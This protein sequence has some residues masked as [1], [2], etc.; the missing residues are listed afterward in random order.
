MLSPKSTKLTLFTALA[1]SAEIVRADETALDR[2]VKAPDA[3]FTWKVKEER[4][5]GQFTVTRLEMQSQQWRGT[6]WVHDVLIVRP[7]KIRNPDIAFLFVGGSGDGS[8]Q[9][10]LLK[11]VAD[12][13]GAL[14][15]VVADVPNQPL[16]GGRVE[17][18]LIA[19]TF[20]QFA[21]TGDE[22]WPLLLPM[23][24]S[25]VRG[26]DAIEQ[27]TS[28]TSM[29]RVERFVL[30][31]ASKRGWTTWLAAAVDRRVVG[32]APMVFDMLNM[33]AQTAWAQKVYGRQSERIHD[34]S[35]ADLISRIDD[36]QIARLREWVDPYAYR[37]RYTIPKLVLLGT[38]DPYWTVDS[39]RHYWPGI[40][41]PK[42]IHQT[43]NAGH[44][45]GGG[46]DAINSLATFF[47]AVAERK[48]L[49]KLEWSV[50]R[51]NVESVLQ[52][53]ADQPMKTARLWLASS[54]DRDFRDEQWHSQ[55][56]SLE[57]AGKRVAAS[58]RPPLE[59]H[60]AFFI[61]AEFVL[62]G[63]LYR[64]STEALVT[65]DMRE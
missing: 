34:Y 33:K 28:R 19:Y 10:G 35:D 4:K 11:T 37:E 43:P 65:P 9:L 41:G 13:G 58:I 56:L 61:E 59:G 44:D 7:Q 51:Q 2:Y 40:S 48:A 45:L 49:P 42:W 25:A 8:S 16:H 1:A 63:Q 38:N 21:Q 18:A 54:T 39:L 64:L 57:D 12:R 23:V 29:Q 46:K 22:T 14:A 15:A 52:V 36:P 30:S 62:S 17:D 6:N 32:I 3:A 60:R 53:T 47:Q 31:G 5:Q 50:D 55:K 20:D 24:K 26:M 27:V